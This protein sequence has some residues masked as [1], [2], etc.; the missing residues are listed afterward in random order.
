[1][2]SPGY[3]LLWFRESQKGS[4]SQRKLGMT[5][6]GFRVALIDEKIVNQGQPVVT[7]KM[8]GFSGQP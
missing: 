1:L 4:D 6:Y 2:I 5:E 3:L 8:N 7:N